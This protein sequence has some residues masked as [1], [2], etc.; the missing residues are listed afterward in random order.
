MAF[1]KAILDANTV[2]RIAL[3]N[4]RAHAIAPVVQ[5]I[6]KSSPTTFAGIARELN[7]RG[8]TAHRGGTWTGKQVERLLKRLKD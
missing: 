2:A 6:Q 1:S 5:E 3:A 7:A 8:I 4:A